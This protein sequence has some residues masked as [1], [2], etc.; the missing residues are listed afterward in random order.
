[1]ADKPSRAVVVYG[2]GFAGMV[3][4]S[5]AGLHSLAS[6]GSCG[7]LA[8]RV[9]PSSAEIQHSR[10]IR[11]LSQL[12][13][14]YDSLDALNKEL[15]EI[16]PNL[17]VQNRFSGLRAAF[18]SA[19]SR[20]VSFGKKL[21]FRPLDIDELVKKEAMP[22]QS[23]IASELLALLGLSEGKVS[24]NNDVDLVFLHIKA[25][26][27]IR[28]QKDKIAI[29]AGS[30]FLDGLVSSVMGSAQPGSDVAARFH[31][32]VVLS[33][34]ETAEDEGGASSALI[35]PLKKDTD[36][37]LLQPCQSYCFKGGKRLDN[38]RH[39]HPMLV[40]QLQEG[41]TRRDMAGEFSFQEFQK[42][43]GNL[44]ILA[45]H[46]LHE[47]AFKLWRAPKYGA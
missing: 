41:V 16:D 3:N 4:Q 21:G 5:H 24:E 33:F 27:E 44:T 8:L 2:E 10:E 26:Q 19:D 7:F 11:E 17:Q 45:D 39:H 32:S 12:L 40:A 14:A 13:D 38:I 46:F 37:S 47:I 22:A 23:A 34:D 43:S 15:N 6:L 42:R 25:G 31:F 36:L 35:S 29:T 1:M 20:I 30:D 18:F 9:S 28:A